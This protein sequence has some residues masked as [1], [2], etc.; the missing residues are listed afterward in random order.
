MHNEG[1]HTLYVIRRF[2]GL[3]VQYYDILYLEKD[4]YF[5]MHG[6][7]KMPRVMYFTPFI[8][9]RFVKSQIG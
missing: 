6:K 9:Y 1:F 2:K 4:K 3:H 5:E 8:Q 7:K